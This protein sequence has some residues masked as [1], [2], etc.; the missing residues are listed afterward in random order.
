MAWLQSTRAADARRPARDIIDA[1]VENMR[2]NREEL[3]YS[4]LAPHRYIVYLHPAEH[5]RLEGVLP[6][7][8]GETCRALGDALDTLNQRARWQ[9]WLDRVRRAPRAATLTSASWDVEFLVDPDDE[10]K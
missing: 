8:R 3:K 2:A 4:T 1:V 7:V 5:A 9:Q 10:L 6:I